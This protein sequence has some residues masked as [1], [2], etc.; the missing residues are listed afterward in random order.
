[1]VTMVNG[2]EIMIRLQQAMARKYLRYISNG[3]T[4]EEASNKLYIKMIK[5]QSQMHLNPANFSKLIANSYEDDIELQNKMKKMKE[6]SS[7]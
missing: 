5:T 1:M 2:S 3:M 6:F 7:D 4:H